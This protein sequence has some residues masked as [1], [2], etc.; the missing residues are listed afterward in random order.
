MT[1]DNEAYYNPYEGMTAVELAKRMS[2]AAEQVAIH[3]GRRKDAQKILDDI[4]K[5]ALPEAMENEGLQN[6]KVAD[7][8]R[9]SIRSDVYAQISAENKDM[10]FDWLRGTGHG[11][12]IKDTVHAATLKSLL[13]TMIREGKE[14]PPEELV[15]VTPYS[16]AVLTRTKS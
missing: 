9:F 10:A 13:K 12:I 11:G 4:R 5:Y 6:M 1:G 15:K 14:L 2:T 3:D 16:I 8:G 7:V